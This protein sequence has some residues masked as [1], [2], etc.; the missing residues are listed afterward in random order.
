MRGLIELF[1]RDNEMGRARGENSREIPQ[2]MSS[3]F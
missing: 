2:L 3:S 1:I